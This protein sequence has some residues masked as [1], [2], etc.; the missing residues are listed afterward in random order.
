MQREIGL[1]SIDELRGL[2][3]LEPLPDGAGASYTPLAVMQSQ[4]Q[5]GITP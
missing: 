5:K 4:M 3:D 1:R 2:E